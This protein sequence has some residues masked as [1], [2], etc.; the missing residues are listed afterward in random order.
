MLMKAPDVVRVDR[1]VR[2]QLQDAE[3]YLVVCVAPHGPER[4]CLR[5]TECQAIANIG[6]PAA[7]IIF[8]RVLLQLCNLAEPLC[9]CVNG[10][11]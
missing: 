10:R 6:E 8:C 9:T 7:V 5:D 4:A 1:Q 11:A 3:C 2:H